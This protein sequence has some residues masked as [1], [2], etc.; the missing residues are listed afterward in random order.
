[1]C[2][3]SIRSFVVEQRFSYLSPTLSLCF[4]I[5]TIGASFYFVSYRSFLCNVVPTYC[6]ASPPLTFLFH[7]FVR[8][9][10]MSRLRV[11][12]RTRVLGMMCVSVCVILLYVL[13]MSMRCMYVYAGVYAHRRIKNVLYTCMRVCI[14]ARF[15]R[16]LETVRGRTH[17]GFRVAVWRA[18]RTEPCKALF[19]SRIMAVRM[20]GVGEGG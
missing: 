6:T 3:P 14:Y 18:E 8:A 19:W 4:T 7:R 17:I 2:V 13:G 1:M 20:V 9:S 11:L 5:H 12:F 10:Y 15:G 16:S